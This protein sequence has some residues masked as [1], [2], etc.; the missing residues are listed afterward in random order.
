MGK[1]FFLSALSRQDAAK[2][3]PDSVSSTSEASEFV[4][5]KTKRKIGAANKITA[6]R[7]WD[8]LTE[9]QKTKTGSAKTWFQKGEDSFIF[10]TAIPICSMP[11]IFI[12]SNSHP[13]SL[14][15]NL[16]YVH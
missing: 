11:I 4:S 3:M 10:F 12:I 14:M 16:F 15:P 7:Y 6:K 2:L 9:S 5:K 1:I 13:G 8:S